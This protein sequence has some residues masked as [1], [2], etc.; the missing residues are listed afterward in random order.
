[1]YTPI[2]PEFPVGFRNLIWEEELN[3]QYS[4]SKEIARSGCESLCHTREYVG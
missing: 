1:M 3:E 2:A 4:N